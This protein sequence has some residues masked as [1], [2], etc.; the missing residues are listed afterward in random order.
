MARLSR[1]ESQTLTRRRI[2]DTARR[3]LLRH[4]YHG[5]SLEQIAEAAGFSK[6]AIYS[7]FASKEELCLAVLDEHYAAQ[8]H[9]LQQALLDAEGTV[10]ARLDTFERWWEKVVA[11]RDWRLLAVEFAL[12]ARRNRSLR[13]DLARRDQTARAAIAALLEEQVRQVGIELPMPA[14]ELAIALLGVGTGISLQRLLDPEVPT[15][16]LTDAMRLFVRGTR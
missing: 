10:D 5:T 15:S 16:V 7:N 6:G 9:E 8:F 3:E 14:D 4:G 11:E 12:L 1:E 13:R 2:L